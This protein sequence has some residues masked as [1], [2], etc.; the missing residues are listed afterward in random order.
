MYNTYEISY[1]ITLE[2]ES[3]SIKEEIIAKDVENVIEK[4]KNRYK[5][6]ISGEFD[7]DVYCINIKGLKICEE[8]DDEILYRDL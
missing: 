6:I 4:V 8:I 1:V 2:N 7:L 3:F 5:K